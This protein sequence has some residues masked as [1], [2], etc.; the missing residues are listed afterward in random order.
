MVSIYW[1]SKRGALSSSAGTTWASLLKLNSVP[2]MPGTATRTVA[3]NRVPMMTKA[4]IHWS[5]MI[6]MKNCCTPMEAVRTLS[7]KPIV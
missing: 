4:K 7:A 1:S 3:T 2:K 5:A 6:L